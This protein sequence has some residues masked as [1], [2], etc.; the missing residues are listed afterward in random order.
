MTEV[1]PLT[2]E[3]IAK[4]G[5]DA[6][7][8]ALSLPLLWGRA[9]ATIRLR[10]QEREQA[11]AAATRA[12]TDAE[13]STQRWEA[14]SQ[15]W[16][17]TLRQRDFALA[18]RDKWRQIA[19]DQAMRFDGWMS[20]NV[21]AINAQI[22]LDR[23]EAVALLADVEAYFDKGIEINDLISYALRRS[24]HQSRSMI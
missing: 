1:Q 10:T 20:R 18:E 12:T 11:M 24:H 16:A 22:A 8:G 13:F 9:L 21:D 15:K 23:I 3:E 2:D 7:C 5:D 19:D 4:I 14:A 6:K 17:E